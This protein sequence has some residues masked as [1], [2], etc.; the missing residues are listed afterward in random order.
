M[1]SMPK[2]KEIANKV[3]EGLA[4]DS[5]YTGARN[6]AVKLAWDYEKADV[7]MGGRGSSD[8]DDAQCQE[9]K[10]TGKVRGAEGH[11]QKNVA[12]HPED[13]GDP[14]NIKFYKSRKEHL[15][16]GITV[17]FT[18]QAMHLKLTKTKCLRKQIARESLEMK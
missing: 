7:E 18:I 16:K 11:H 12:D 8:W 9:I 6:D 10:E 5:E 15:E 4:K 13:Q 2:E 3:A 17:T 14:D 1:L